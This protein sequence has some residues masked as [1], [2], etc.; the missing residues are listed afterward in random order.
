LVA[1]DIWRWA[2]YHAVLFLAGLQTIPSDYYEAADIDGANMIQKFFRI[3][4]PM[5]KPIILMN[6]TIALMGAFSV[7]DI[8]FVM[9]RGGPYR[10][11]QVVLTYMFERSFTGTGT[12]LGVGSA[13]AYLLF[14]V[15]LIITVF[16]TRSMNKSNT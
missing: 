8:V 14:I 15:I 2:G 12:N 4:I 5:L 10:S 3:T 7:F 16:Q 11:T 6:T 13:I 9:T 1:V